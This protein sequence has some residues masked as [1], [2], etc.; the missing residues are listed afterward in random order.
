V[1][2]LFHILIGAGKPRHKFI[3]ESVRP[4]RFP[5]CK[6]K[7]YVRSLHA[8]IDVWI[9][10]DLHSTD[11]LKHGHGNSVNRCDYI[12]C[13]HDNWPPDQPRPAAQTVGHGPAFA[14]IYLMLVQH[15]MEERI[16]VQL[17]RRFSAH[18]VHVQAYERPCHHF[19]VLS[20][21]AVAR[22]DRAARVRPAPS[23]RP[24]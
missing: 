1:L 3:V 9:E 17:E 12:V 19:F 4:G 22:Q 23:A 2:A 6:A 20:R 21:R 18:R 11:F 16:A 24:P 8:Y 5:D 15:C 10:F 7:E 13:W 14:G